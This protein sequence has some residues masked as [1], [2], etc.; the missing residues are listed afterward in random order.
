MSV[1]LHSI[2]SDGFFFIMVTCHSLTRYGRTKYFFWS[3]FQTVAKD[4]VPLKIVH[5]D[6]HVIHV[7]CLC[8]KALGKNG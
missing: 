7:M 8:K 6:Y 4:L 3:K 2:A 5:S 1:S